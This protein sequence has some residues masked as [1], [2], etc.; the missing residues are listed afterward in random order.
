[1]LKGNVSIETEVPKLSAAGNPYRTGFM[2]CDPADWNL[3]LGKK[4]GYV[5]TYQEPY[6][7]VI[8]GVT[9]QGRLVFVTY[10]EG[11]ITVVDCATQEDLD[12][13]IATAKEFYDT[14]YKT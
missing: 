5:D 2:L 8:Y 6:C 12:R 10:C 9:A 3:K 13:E 14:R 7:Q 4:L 1:M 11:D